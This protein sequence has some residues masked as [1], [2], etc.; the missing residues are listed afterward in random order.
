MRRSMACRRLRHSRTGPHKDER[1]RDRQGDLI[2]R[3]PMVGVKVGLGKDR[4]RKAKGFVL[5][6]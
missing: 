1:E 4:E 5:D 3:S 6:V 2:N